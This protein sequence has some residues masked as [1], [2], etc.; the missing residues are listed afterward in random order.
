M[1]LGD[2]ENSVSYWKTEGILWDRV[3]SVCGI[4][5]WE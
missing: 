4:G 1:L 2:R 5:G 3:N